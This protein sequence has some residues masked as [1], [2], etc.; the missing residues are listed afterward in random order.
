M[1]DLLKEAVELLKTV[2]GYDLDSVEITV[3]GS[4]YKLAKAPPVAAIP[5][6]I[7]SVGE[8]NAYKEGLQAS[9]GL[10]APIEEDLEGSFVDIVSPMVGMFYRATEPGRPPM[11][12]LGQIVTPGEPVCIIEAMKLMNVIKSDVNGKIIKILAENETPVQAGQVLFL[13]D[14]VRPMGTGNEGI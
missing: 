5:V 1:S 12:E 7:P 4:T 6:P 14:P 2:Q 10:A 13:V 3:D 11:V 9:K 8:A